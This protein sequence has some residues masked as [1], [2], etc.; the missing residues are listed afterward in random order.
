[1]SSYKTEFTL[2]ERDSLQDM[3]NV[4]KNMA[5]VYAMALTEGASKGFRTVVKNC[6]T[7]TTSDQLSVFLNMTEHD[8]YRVEAAS[9]DMKCEQKSKFSK[10]IKTLS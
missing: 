6:F 7:D 8:Y 2:N 4:E 10:V 1:M 5:K 3:L 9:E